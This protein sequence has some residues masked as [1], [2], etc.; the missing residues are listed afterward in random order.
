MLRP[1]FDNV[2]FNVDRSTTVPFA[3]AVTHNAARLAGSQFLSHP[4]SLKGMHEET[5]L[6]RNDRHNKVV[7]ERAT[8]IRRNSSGQGRA[9][10]MLER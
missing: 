3:D 5:M 6:S 9:S 8:V 2:H 4:I 10:S 7:N 1:G